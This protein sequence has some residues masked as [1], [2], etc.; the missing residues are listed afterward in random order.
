MCP[1]VLRWSP[2]AAVH[3]LPAL[4]SWEP[5]AG[6]GV[7][8]QLARWKLI[9]FLAKKSAEIWR[10]VRGLAAEQNPQESEP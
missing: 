10:P 9:K 8:V 6:A 5:A 7:F 4:P 2:G 1:V 3:M